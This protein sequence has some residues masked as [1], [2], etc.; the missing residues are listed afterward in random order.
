MKV[1]RIVANI[2]TADPE[3]ADAFYS[4]FAGARCLTIHNIACHDAICS[5][6]AGDQCRRLRS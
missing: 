2:L 1:K 6:P 4:K 5:L 3:S